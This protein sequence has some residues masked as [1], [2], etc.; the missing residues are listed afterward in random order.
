MKKP[1]FIMNFHRKYLRNSIYFL[2]NFY[3]FE[4]LFKSFYHYLGKSIALN[5]MSSNYVKDV[6]FK[7]SFATKEIEVA[8]SDID[9][10]VI[11]KENLS[12]EEFSEF[13]L[14]VHQIKERTLIKLSG[15]IKEIEIFDEG[16]FDSKDFQKYSRYYS[17]RQFSEKEVLIVDTLEPE[18]LVDFNLFKFCLNVPYYKG[19]IHSYK[20]YNRMLNKFLKLDSK[21]NHLLTKNTADDIHEKYNSIIKLFEKFLAKEKV[22][23]ETYLKL[24][25]F[26]HYT[27]KVENQLIEV[28]KVEDEIE[29][30]KH[31]TYMPDG[32]MDFITSPSYLGP[33]AISYIQK[34]WIDN[35]DYRKRNMIMRFH[36]RAI[37]LEHLYA[38][39]KSPFIL[40]LYKDILNKETKNIKTIYL[41][42]MSFYKQES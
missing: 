18:E 3:P 41:D 11:L 4:Y 19:Y 35:L 23:S 16:D 2:S 28:F 32:K 21:N 12:F 14:F 7:G 17:W 5:L 20:I 9:I 6:Y 26:G 33:K 39:D 31:F 1:Y 37:L 25:S 27:P 30:K 22:V 24:N 15:L 29:L 34:N 40:C 38:K 42:L 10:A 36:W 8:A 13:V